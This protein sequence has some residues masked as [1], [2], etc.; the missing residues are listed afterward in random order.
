MIDLNYVIG[1][2]ADHVYFVYPSTDILLDIS[3]DILVNMSTESGFRIV[4]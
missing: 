1:D 4:G 2:G 3:A